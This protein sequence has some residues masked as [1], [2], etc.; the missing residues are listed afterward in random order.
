V[1]FFAKVVLDLTDHPRVM[2]IPL[3]LQDACLGTWLRALLYTRK[4]EL[5][6][7]CPGNVIET[8][9]GEDVLRWL[10]SVDLFARHEQ[11]G[12]H[13]YLVLRYERHNDTR[14]DIEERRRTDR[15]RKAK[16][17]PK[18][19]QTESAR[20][21]TGKITERRRKVVGFPGS[22]SDS[23]SSLSPSGSPLSDHSN[24]PPPGDLY[25]TRAK[26]VVTRDPPRL[27]ETLTQRQLDEERARQ[28]RAAADFDLNKPEKRKAA[29]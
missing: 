29:R 14:A 26:S 25:G 3:V 7:F 11:N 15:N 24:L 16:A 20:I 10:V 8:T 19:K 23:D 28:L 4:H 5:D 27:P 6:G 12:A 22:D 9:A 1:T 21:R 2:R 17:V 18:G 13:G